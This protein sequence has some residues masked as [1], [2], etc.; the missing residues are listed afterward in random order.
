MGNRQVLRDTTRSQSMLELTPAI[1]PRRSAGRLYKLALA[2]ITFL[3]V[4]LLADPLVWDPVR[5]S[6]YARGLDT[7]DEAEARV[8]LE[9]LHQIGPRGE[10][11]VLSLL[12]DS[13]MQ[14]RRRAVWYI[15]HY[16]PEQTEHLLLEALQDRDDDV[17][18]AAE[19]SLYGLWSKSESVEANRFFFVG[20]G[21]M[22]KGSWDEAIEAFSRA[23][24][25]D[26]GFVECK[27]LI[28]TAHA[29]AGRPDR[30]IEAYQQTVELKPCHFSAMRRLAA[31]YAKQGEQNKA[32]AY[33]KKAREIFPYYTGA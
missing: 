11:A 22:Q 20:V 1:T 33:L 19:G 4:A 21:H 13:T 12:S 15:Y 31:L 29:N 17:W 6:Y 27:N 16:Q 23:Y 2:A 18:R 25:I 26:P 10:Q 8:L 32:L 14:R 24:E 7:A 30:A 5:A 3:G 28:A 9:R